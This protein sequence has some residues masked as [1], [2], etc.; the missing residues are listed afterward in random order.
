MISEVGMEVASAAAAKSFLTD[1][2]NKTKSVAGGKGLGVFYWEPE[3]HAGWQGY[4]MGAFDR[5]GR[6][7][8]ALDAFK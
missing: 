2:I 4:T 6:P 5:D 8:E 7:T 3:C 1:I